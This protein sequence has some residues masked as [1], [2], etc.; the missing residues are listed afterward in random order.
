[1]DRVPGSGI[2]ANFRYMCQTTMIR[3]FQP[4]PVM[5]DVAARDPLIGQKLDHYRLTNRIGSGGM[6]VVYLAYDEQLQREVAVKVIST[7]LLAD[8]SAR[9]RFRKEALALA[10]LNHPN[11]ETAHEFGSQGT[12]DFLVTE[13]VLGTT[14]DERLAT[15][16]L[17]PKDVVRLGTQLAQGLS[18][19]HEQGIVH[20]DLKPANLRLTPD[21][22]LKILDFGLA[23]LISKDSDLETT[24]TLT[25]SGAV[26]G[27]L[28]YMAPEQLRGEAADARSDIWACG[29]VLYEMVTGHRPFPETNGP[30]LIEAILNR[31]PQ[32]PSRI[33]RQ[34]SAGLENV[35]LKALAK[36]PAYRYQTARELSVDLERLTAGVTPLAKSRNRLWSPR[37]AASYLIVLLAIAVGGYF[38]SHRDKPSTSFENAPVKPRR[39]V[40]VLGFKNLAGKPELAWLS[41]A[42][43]EML[44]TELAAGEQ[45]RTVPGENVARMRMSLALPDADSYGK[46]TLTK[47]RQTLGTDDVVVGSFVP[48]G[49][50][51]IRLDLRLQDAIEGET[52]VS[53]SQKGSEDQL[54]ELVSKAGAVLRVKLGASD[55]SESQ[56]AT[57]RASM[58]FNPEAARLYAE[59]LSRLRIYDALAA[60]GLLEKAVALEPDFALTH[61]ALASAWQGLGYDTKAKEEAKKAFELSKG[62]SREDSLLVEA[63]Y[64]EATSDWDTAVEN[65][66]TLFSFYPDNL[67]YGLQLSRALSSAGKGQDAL[68]TVESLRRF[69]PPQRDDPR[70][71]LTEGTAAMSLGDFQKVEA[72]AARAVEK[73]QA[74]GSKLLVADARLG[75]CM[76]FRHLGKL[77]EAIGS[78]QAAQSIYAATNERGG[79]A[80]VLTNLANIYY[81]QGDLAGAKKV[82]EEA[83]KI[84]REIGNLRGTAGALDNVANVVGDLGDPIAA[85]K[86]SEESLRIYRE[87]SDYTGMGETLNNIAT[88]EQ[89]AGNYGAATKAMAGALEIWRKTGNRNGI[90]TTTNNLADLLLN[91]GEIAQA[92]SKYQEA[93]KIFRDSSQ[94]SNSAYPLFGLGE[95]LSARGNLAGAKDKY[96]ETL[97]ISLQNSDKHQSAV[98][99][100]GLGQNFLRQG[101][102]AAALE[103]HKAALAIR[104]EI[105]E[106][107]A[108]AESTLALASLALEERHLLDA[109]KLAQAAL[110]EFQAEKLRDDE[111]LARVVLAWSLLEQHKAVESRKQVGLAANLASKS[112]IFEVR[113][114]F[115]IADAVTKSA[116][117]DHAGAAKDLETS[118]EETVTR[119]YLGYQYEVELALGTVEMKS[120]N[121][122]AGRARLQDLEK[123]SSAKGFH[124]IA[125]KA[126]AAANIFL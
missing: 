12:I 99:L 97:A 81:G 88:E 25:Q 60:R 48:V 4:S 109:E 69:P 83:L 37:L 16:S 80:K 123:E 118:L 50:G 125:R 111:V 107:G 112:P 90:A 38:F 64:R 42:L 86:L 103:K 26:T 101:D 3:R 9:R 30:L 74:Q 91:Q 70:I 117:G 22:R 39:S 116:M 67:N 76:A 122:T 75:Q 44:T 93:L 55:L 66:R 45:L 29:A 54:D 47:I 33:N 35:I 40:A 92:E 18:A 23:Q 20:R 53:I 120:G 41:T 15:G 95:V 102:L 124:L 108:T 63:R 5:S 87:I 56:S 59:G 43:S 13:Y 98:A 51:Q 28:P 11:I 72:C 89:V 19:A 1:M 105:G 119:G 2:T 71:D 110:D 126:T 36:E 6:G 34:V 14:L 79:L 115:A 58:P 24:L 62:L 52:L 100:F 32:L 94:T 65:Y 61:V 73:G 10:K 8:E 114:R 84:Y 104:K 113:T 46:E 57:V 77:T 31:E 96:E 121:T 106:K 68:A 49:T 82:Y 78:C 17:S 85:R 7:G 21:G 27:T